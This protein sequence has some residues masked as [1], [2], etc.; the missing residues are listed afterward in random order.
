MKLALVLILFSSMHFMHII[1]LKILPDKLSTI[2][3]NENIINLKLSINLSLCV[4]VLFYRIFLSIGT[5]KVIYFSIFSR[6]Q[7]RSP[8]NFFA[9]SLILK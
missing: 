5:E 3:D 8:L 4:I 1:L 7:S 9:N 2:F 6:I